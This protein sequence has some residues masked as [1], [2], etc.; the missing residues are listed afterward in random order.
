V[1]TDEEHPAT[2][3]HAEASHR[4]RVGRTA[5]LDHHVEPDTVAEFSQER[6]EIMAGGVDRFVGTQLGC[7]QSRPDY[8]P[9]CCLRF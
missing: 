9:R 2:A 8:E 5:G 4:R 6:R 7:C 3:A 1:H